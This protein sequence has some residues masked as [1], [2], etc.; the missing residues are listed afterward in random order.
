LSV[1]EGHYNSPVLDK[2]RWLLENQHELRLLALGDSITSGATVQSGGGYLFTITGRLRDRGVRVTLANHSKA[3]RT[4]RDAVEL[5]E[6]AALDFHPDLTIVAFGVNDEKPVRK[7]HVSPADYG[8]FVSKI[9]WW[10]FT[11]SESDVIIVTP[12]PIPPNTATEYAEAARSTGWPIA[13]ITAAW[14]PG[15]IADD[16]EHPNDE[17]HRVYAESILALL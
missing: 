12:P 16:G 10:C 15:L 1:P 6:Q 7:T 11:R 3:G 17:G 4:S 14:Y 5:A 13:D 8:Y 2:T 9:G